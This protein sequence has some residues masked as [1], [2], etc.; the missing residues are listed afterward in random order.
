[1]LDPERCWSAVRA[2]DA[3]CDGRFF[4]GVVTTGV[5]C[6]PSCPARRPLRANVRFYATAAAAEGEG[7]R[8]CLALPAGGTGGTGSER[9][10]HRRGLPLHR[11]AR[12]CSARLGDLA[13]LA[14]LSP[15]HFQRTFKAVAGV[16][17]REY[18]EA[19]RR[20]RFK[21]ALKASKGVTEAAFEA[22]F[23]SAAGAYE[24]AQLGMT[25]TRYPAGGR[26]VGITYAVTSTAAGELLVAAT[27]R[28]LCSVQFGECA[29]GLVARLRGEFPHAHLVPMDEPHPAAFDAWLAAL[30]RHLAGGQPHLDLPLDVRR[31]AFQTRVWRF[32]QSIPYG[33]VRSY[34]D[35]AAGIGRPNAARA[36]ARACAQNELAVVVP[37]H[38]VIR[39]DGGLAGYRWGLPRKRALLER[40]RGARGRPPDPGRER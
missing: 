5:Y 12:R 6:R 1:M 36:V 40:E 37:C 30:E 4:Y 21:A 33:E 34:G 23:G 7:L 11:R 26:E 35:V 39:G 22:G 20:R 17:P 31:T 28:G 13:K 18:V 14:G 2:R 10:A 16:R 25:P 19:A 15:F 3:A 29:E 38:R 9:R 27:D 8:A 32:L 24:G